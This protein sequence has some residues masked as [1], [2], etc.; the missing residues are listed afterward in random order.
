RKDAHRL[1]EII[2]NIPDSEYKRK[3]EIVWKIGKT[4][5]LGPFTWHYIARSLCRMLEI[6]RNEEIDIPE[7]NELITQIISKGFQGSFQ[8]GKIDS[9]GTI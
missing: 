5:T 9:T 3:Q 4:L 8:F 7:A 6:N 2:T 1:N